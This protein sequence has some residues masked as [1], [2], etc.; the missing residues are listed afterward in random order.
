MD[1]MNEIFANGYSRIP[2]FDGDVKT[3]RVRPPLT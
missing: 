3:V 2:C 1:A